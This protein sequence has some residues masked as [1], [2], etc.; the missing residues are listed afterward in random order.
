M[1]IRF[2]RCTE[3]PIITWFAAGVAFLAVGI[4]QPAFIGIGAAYIAIGIRQNRKG[5]R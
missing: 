5:R 4:R 2:L 1:K 3:M